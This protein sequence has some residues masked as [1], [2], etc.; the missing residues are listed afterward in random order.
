MIWRF[1][2]HVCEIF[3][4]FVCREVF[5]VTFVGCYLSPRWGEAEKKKPHAK[6]MTVATLSFSAFRFFISQKVS[7]FDA[8]SVLIT[9]SSP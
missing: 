9:H 7:N 3:C 6:K 2:I 1:D 5:L 8:L 4:L